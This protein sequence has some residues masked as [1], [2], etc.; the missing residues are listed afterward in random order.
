MLVVIIYKLLYLFSLT[1]PKSFVSLS[2][3]VSVTTVLLVG[4]WAVP[5]KPPPFDTYT[6]YNY[7][8]SPA[9]TCEAVRR[10]LLS[11]A[12]TL[13]EVPAGKIVAIAG[14]K[15]FQV[16]PTHQAE[17]KFN[18]ECDPR[19][20]NAADGTTVF[21]NAEID[22]YSLQQGTSVPA[23]LNVSPIGGLTVPVPTGVTQLVLVSSQTVDDAAWYKSFFDQT[24]EFLVN[25]DIPEDPI[26]SATTPAS[27]AA[28]A[29]APTQSAPQSAAS[30]PKQNLFGTLPAV[31]PSGQSTSS[32]Q[33][34]A[35][36]PK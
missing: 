19:G 31:A 36:V 8:A 28:S 33:P 29:S 35:S 32:T 11:Q 18:A 4:C 7:A 13:D 12:Y 26:P 16:D 21:A 22:Q 30:A 9:R 27:E 10:A 24:N 14:H 1:M 6:A 5:V 23:S 17:L 2:L 3:A 34:A 25:G 20:S 15:A